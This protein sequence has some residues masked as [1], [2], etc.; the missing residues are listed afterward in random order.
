LAGFEP[1]RPCPTA[2]RKGLT[3]RL[4]LWLVIFGQISSQKMANIDDFPLKS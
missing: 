3:G 2:V 4:L 1:W